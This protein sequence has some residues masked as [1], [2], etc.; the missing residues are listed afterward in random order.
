ML[1]ESSE[2]IDRVTG[3]VQGLKDFSRVDKSDWQPVDVHDSIES[4][5]NVLKHELEQKVDVVKQFADLPAI[6]CLPFQLNQ[7]FLNLLMNAYQAIDGRGIITIRTERGADRLR[8][9]VSDSGKGIAPGDLSRI[10]E[11]FFTTKPAGSGP[12]LGLSVAYNIV[13]QHGGTIEAA[14]EPGSG[15]TFTVSLPLARVAPMAAQA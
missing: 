13:K 15:S 3:I 11:P 4:T 12:G 5:L 9:H 14:S 7:V 2:G 8:I 10:F 6:E 1:H